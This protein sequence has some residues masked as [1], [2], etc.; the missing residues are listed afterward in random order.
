MSFQSIVDAVLD[1]VLGWAL[2][3]PSIWAILIL[4]VV[5]GAA[6]TLLQKYMTDQAKMKRLKND[7][8]K[9]QK[10]MKE[11]QKE[12]KQDKMMKVQQKIMPIQMQLMKESFKPLL[13]T[14]IPFLLVFFWLSSHFAYYPLEPGEPFTVTA[15]FAEGAGGE[16]TL[17]VPEEL[18]VD[19]ATK[20]VQD[21]MTSWTLQGPVG[22]YNL[23]LKYSGG[24]FQRD[25][26]ITNEREYVAPEKQFSGVVESFDA[27]NTKLLPLGD[28]SLFGWRP[29]WIFYYILFSI[30]VSLLLKKLLNVA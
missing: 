12:G 21:G 15:Q 20:I 19:N 27:G 22:K 14:M 13:V 8:K 11:L 30:P 17:V 9:L 2:N 29:G 4:S 18:S 23:T 1:P 5:L 10:Q 16:A 25:V 3:I 24:E 7:T 6:S 28:F 26:L